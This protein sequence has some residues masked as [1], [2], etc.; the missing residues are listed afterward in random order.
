MSYLLHRLAKM[1]SERLH[2]R[3]GDGRC[4]WS[5]LGRRSTRIV[6]SATE[7]KARKIVKDQR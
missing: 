5:D 1:G 7:N 3:I 4:F 6:G 2:Q